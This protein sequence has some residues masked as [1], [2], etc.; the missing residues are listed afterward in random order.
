MSLERRTA[1]V[2]GLT[3]L[4][5]ISALLAS[6]W[7][8]F[9]PNPLSSEGSQWWLVFFTLLLLALLSERL[10]I[11]MTEGGSTTSMGFVPQLAAVL[12]IG[13][14]G[15]GLIAALSIVY[16]QVF[17]LRKPAYKAVFNVSQVTLSTLAAGA[18]YLGL[19]GI[20]SLSGL[21]ISVS[22]FLP[23]IVAVVVYFGVNSFLFAYIISVSERRGFLDIWQPLGAMVAVDIVIS[24]LAYFIS[25]FYVQVADPQTQWA[26]WGGAAALLG[27]AVPI[28]ALRYSYGLNIELHQLNRDLL[29]V[30]IKT[31]EAQDPYT[32]GHS[33]RVAEASKQ[34]AQEL[35]LKRTL[36]RNIET[37]ALLHDI[38]KIGRAFSEI[39]RQTGPLSEEQRKL[40]KKHPRRGVE[41]I[42][43]VRSLDEEVLEFVLYH[44]EDFDGTGYPE[45]LSGEDIPLGARVIRVADTVDAMATVRPYREPLTDEEIRSEL[46]RYQRIQFD[47]T[48]VEAALNV[49]I[50]GRAI[51]LQHGPEVAAV[52]GIP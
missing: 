48:V 27:L 13:P 26:G 37:A 15:A 10:G 32:S 35:G 44:H 52:H 9:P 45:G 33:I 41:I 47:P 17:L 49:G 24:V 23:F 36:L 12:L 31:L 20:S 6:L 16:Y 30:L 19:G 46:I 4:A 34:L 8:L 5:A 38:G 42:R 50:V 51:D 25:Y 11:K 7:L 28:V 18:A 3:T 39:L 43:S 40:I 29:R 1:I 2:I 21:G 14:A 22:T